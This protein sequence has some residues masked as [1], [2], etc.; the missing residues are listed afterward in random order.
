MQTYKTLSALEPKKKQQYVVARSLLE[1]GLKRWRQ[2]LESDDD[3][4]WQNFLVLA[5]NTSQGKDTLGDRKILEIGQG[6]MA[7]ICVRD[8]LEDMTK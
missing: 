1:W 8:H 6:I 2:N 3:N 5:Q 4:F 7:A